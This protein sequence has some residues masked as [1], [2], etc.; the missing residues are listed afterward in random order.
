MINGYILT[1]LKKN[2]VSELLEKIQI[3][4]ETITDDDCNIASAAAV[5]E[6]RDV[7]DDFD[8]NEATA[9]DV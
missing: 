3:F 2:V 7:E 8:D 6:D 4:F 9:I 5:D 1:F